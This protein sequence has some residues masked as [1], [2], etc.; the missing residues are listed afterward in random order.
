MIQNILIT[1]F[2]PVFNGEKYFSQNGLLD[3]LNKKTI[4]V[5]IEYLSAAL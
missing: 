5:S 1:I 3:L 2:V 4:S